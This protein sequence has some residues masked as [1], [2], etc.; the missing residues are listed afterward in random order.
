MGIHLCFLLKK[1]MEAK[2]AEISALKDANKD[3]A[4]RMAKFEAFMAAADT[5]KPAPLKAR[6][7]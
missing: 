7:G 3:L 1:E 2:E 6:S 5:A 4:D